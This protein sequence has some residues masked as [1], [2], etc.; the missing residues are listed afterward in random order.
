MLPQDARKK[1]ILRLLGVFIYEQIIW[2]YSLVCLN[3]YLYRPNFV[4]LDSLVCKRKGYET[5]CKKSTVMQQFRDY[6]K[7]QGVQDKQI[8]KI[9]D[10]NRRTL[11]T[12]D[13][14]PERAY[15]GNQK[16]NVIDC[17]LDN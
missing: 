17:L 15:K 8:E 2:I 9:N 14:E 12:M 11:L 5:N 7:L 1:C 13:V 16:I 4:F 10:Y 6:L 3:P